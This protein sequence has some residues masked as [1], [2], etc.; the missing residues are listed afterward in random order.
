MRDPRGCGQNFFYDLGGR[1]LGEQYVACGEAQ[2]SATDLPI[3]GVPSG[4][5]GESVLAASAM[6]DVR[7]EY[8]ALP[9]WLPSGTTLPSGIGG[10]LGRATGVTDRGQ[11]SAVAY[12][13]RGLAIWTARQ[14]ALIPN[15][16]ALTTSAM[17]ATYPTITEAAPSSGS[18]AFDEAHTYVETTTSNHAGAARRLT[19]PRDPDFGGGARPA[20]RR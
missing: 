3:E 13:A 11:R 4:S 9:T 17:G 14:M 10:Y 1:L 20:R 8:D 19:L 16:L 7:Y 2:T 12:D 18:V 6:V 15:R 5:I